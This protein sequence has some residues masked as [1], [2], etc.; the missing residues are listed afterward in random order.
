M[1]S[2]LSIG[3]SS[4]TGTFVGVEVARGTGVALGL[5]AGL[6]RGVNVIVEEAGL[7]E[8]TEAVG[9]PLS[10]TGGEPHE[11]KMSALMIQAS[12]F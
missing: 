12:R 10:P 11:L 9:V 1:L 3:N 2:G 6:E 4:S 7:V 8:R 5:I